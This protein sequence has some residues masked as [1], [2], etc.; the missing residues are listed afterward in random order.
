M[1]L[2]HL[3]HQPIGRRHR[4][5]G[6]KEKNRFGRL[7]SVGLHQVSLDFLQKRTHR[8]VVWRQLKCKRSA[9]PKIASSSYIFRLL[10]IRCTW[11]CLLHNYRHSIVGCQD[12]RRQFSSAFC[13]N[14]TRPKTSSYFM[15]QHSTKSSAFG[16]CFIDAEQHRARF[17]R[18]SSPSSFSVWNFDVRMLQSRH[19][20]NKLACTNIQ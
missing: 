14:K 2:V 12:F 8:H 11:M 10:N 4:V 13:E 1:L 16:R 18:K 3:R 20:W 15:N 5:G 9:A 19:K 7:V 6:H 17:A